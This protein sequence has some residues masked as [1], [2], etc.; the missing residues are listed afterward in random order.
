MQ[1][2]E[3][4]SPG[5]ACSPRSAPCPGIFSSHVLSSSPAPSPLCP[6]QGWSVA[7]D[8]VM[9]LRQSPPAA[10]GQP[11]AP[12]V[13]PAPGYSR[14]AAA[15]RPRLLGVTLREPLCPLP[16]APRAP[17][18]RCDLPQ[19]SPRG[20]RGV[21]AALLHPQKTSSP[22]HSAP[23]LSRGVSIPPPFPLKRH[24]QGSL[25][26]QRGCR[27]GVLPPVSPQPVPP[28]W[29][30]PGVSILWHPLS[31]TPSS[32]TRTPPSATATPT[33][34]TCGAEPHVCGSWQVPAGSGH[35]HPWAHV[36]HHPRAGT[37]M[38]DSPWPT[39]DR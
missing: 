15:A 39:G 28:C 4:G 30:L 27:E 33:V 21:H 12:K 38:R 29:H 6:R 31:P 16:I 34:G 5:G 17:P 2:G 13:S 36:P 24:P 7:G 9:R 25:V 32:G 10:P 23:C 1:V 18:A 26:V 22:R 19:E 20:H 14:A 3:G 8:G 11:P 37:G 35:P